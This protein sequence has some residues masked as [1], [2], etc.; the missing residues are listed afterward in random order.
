MHAYALAFV[1]SKH[2]SQATRKKENERKI[3]TFPF[4]QAPQKK[5]IGKFF[6]ITTSNIA[7]ANTFCESLIVATSHNYSSSGARTTIS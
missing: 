2:L 3:V 1:R 5:P 4:L 7:I 6:P